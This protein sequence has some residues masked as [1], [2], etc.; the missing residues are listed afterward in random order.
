MSYRHLSLTCEC[1][2]V[3][4]RILE[5]GFTAQHELVVHYWCSECRRAVGFSKPLTDCWRDCPE[6]EVVPELPAPQALETAADAK[7]LQ[8]IGIRCLEENVDSR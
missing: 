6:P 8:S 1:G 4:D 7:F 5:V 2:E 3:P